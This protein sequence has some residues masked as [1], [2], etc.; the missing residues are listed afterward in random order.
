MM[1]S[2]GWR[3]NRI[4]VEFDA[5]GTVD[6]ADS[7]AAS[8]KNTRNGK[9]RSKSA[10]TGKPP[11]RQVTSPP[12]HRL[13]SIA[14]PRLAMRFSARRAAKPGEKR[15]KIVQKS[16]KSCNRLQGEAWQNPCSCPTIFLSASAT[17][18]HQHSTLGTPPFPPFAPVQEP[19][20][21]RRA[22]W[23]WC[24]NATNHDKSRQIATPAC[25][26]VSGGPILDRFWTDFPLGPRPRPG[27]QF[28]V[29]GMFS[30]H[31]ISPL[32]RMARL[33]GKWSFPKPCH[34]LPFCAKTGQEL[35]SLCSGMRTFHEDSNLGAR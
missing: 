2:Q 10:K 19:L 8:P 23:R 20:F 30:G 1:R 24:Q 22:R 5:A 32:F 34:F 14:S 29:F 3:F 11:P 18:P 16:A 26:R 15:C 35:I 12:L 6:P 27:S 31:R 25:H 4:T 33:A 13:S 7:W 17:L 21:S 28:G 9:I